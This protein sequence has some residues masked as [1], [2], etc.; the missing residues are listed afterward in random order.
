MNVHLSVALAAILLLSLTT[1]CSAL[2]PGLAV[3][4]T[5]LDAASGAP[6]AG[7]EITSGQASAQSDSQGH[8]LLPSAVHNG[9]VMMALDGYQPVESMAEGGSWLKRE[10]TLDASLR[11]VTLDGA[12]TDAAS[13]QPLAGASV[14]VA[15]ATVVTGADGAFHFLR[16]PR[17]AAIVVQA[18]GYQ[19][20]SLTFGGEATLPVALNL[21]SLTAL[22]VDERDNSPLAQATVTFGGRDV[23]ANTSGQAVLRGV[24]QQAPVSGRAD[25]YLAATARYG[26][27]GVLT[28]TLPANTVSGEVREQTSGQP[29]RG[30]T[31]TL[32]QANATTSIPSG[33]TGTL[34]LRGV[35]SGAVLSAS[36]PEH[37]SAVV[38]YTG[39]PSVSFTLRP[40]MLRGVVSDRFTGQ[41]MAGI[42]VTLQQA[43][44]ARSTRSDD[45]G[46]FQFTHAPPAAAISA[47]AP[48]HAATAITYT[49][50]ITTNLT[51]RPNTL[52][53][54]VRESKDGKPVAGATVSVGDVSAK[55]GPNGEY[56]LSGIPDGLPLVVE[57]TGHDR[58]RTAI[59]PLT[60]LDVNWQTA[61]V[62]AIYIPFYL[63]TVPDRVRSLINFAERSGMNALVIDIK[64]DDGYLDYP[65]QVPLAKEIK[66]QYAG[67]MI[68]ID[69]VLKLAKQRGM[70]TIAR[71]VVF[72]DNLLAESRPEMAVKDKR[73]N[74]LWD[75][76][77]NG[78]TYWVDPFRK[79][80]VDYNASI[81]EEA[82]KLG[83]DEIQFDYIRF[84]PACVTGAPLAAA[85]FA[86]TPTL[87][88]RVAAI[89]TFLAETQ[90]RLKP[91]GVATS[92][93][94]FGWTLFRE[95]DAYIGQRMENMAKY[96]DYV[97][98]MVYPSTWEPGAL[99][100]D[101]PP[102]HPYEIVYESIKYGLERLKDL[103]G[104]KIR[105]W[106]QDFD[107]YQSRDLPYGR[108][109]L[110]AQRRAAAD[111]GASGWM[112]WNAGG[113][114]TEETAP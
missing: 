97:S 11:P 73:T 6:L 84:P 27:G 74:A 90:K 32:N 37:A 15:G 1:A 16:V 23:A 112:L 8:Y 44:G 107:D 2:T 4:G 109:E 85:S 89:E 68:G 5:V 52:R 96:V 101:Y 95:D 48:G 108:K 99:G 77:G 43:D 64:S 40:D 76:C 70:Y 3:R 114:Y 51:L 39:Q 80:V 69:E 50:Q 19:Q 81:A 36:G 67:S 93:D 30:I 61:D 83:F 35:R 65:S 57:A 62:R 25:G 18:D 12:V 103:P 7:V 86:V 34:Q 56:A 82:G 104:V 29:L 78:T 20:H 53:G 105:P 59:G 102:A 60:T 110:D 79:D 100:L 49:G 9:K 58:I 55:T 24:K 92:V 17:S 63:L 91:L 88:T 38:T 72:K 41:P 98:P 111:A 31:V 42:S 54:V 106:L 47:T 66:A 14:S 33:A 113:V 13:G 45:G 87:E 22:V 26:G 71:M 75:D 10:I 28:V 21:N 46:R 94:T